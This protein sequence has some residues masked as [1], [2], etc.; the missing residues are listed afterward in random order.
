MRTVVHLL[1]SR[2]AIVGG[3]VF[4]TLL[5]AVALVGTVADAVTR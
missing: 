2:A 1:N 5:L 3:R 4:V